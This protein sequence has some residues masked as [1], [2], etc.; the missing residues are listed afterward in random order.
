MKK[1]PIPRRQDGF[2]YIAAVIL[3]VVMAGMAIAVVRLNATQ[4]NSATGAV[5]TA[6]ASQ[7]SRAGLEWAFYQLR[8]KNTAGC[9]SATLSDFQADSGFR[10]SLSCRVTAYNEGQ[11]PAD[12]SVL[13]KNLYQVEAVACNGAAGACPDNASSTKPEYTERRR[14]ATICITAAGDDCY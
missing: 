14:I 5:L 8:T 2:A 9:T 4:A 6:R 7:A 11:N 10:V 3:L 1:N 13:V 12:G